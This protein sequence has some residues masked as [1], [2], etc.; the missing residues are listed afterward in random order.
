MNPSEGIQFGP[1]IELLFSLSIII[2]NDQQLVDD[3]AIDFDTFLPTGF[4]K[5]F[6]ELF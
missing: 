6:N 4:E 3:F 1:I 5:L 2:Q